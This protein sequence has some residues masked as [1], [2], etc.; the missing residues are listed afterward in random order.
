VFTLGPMAHATLVMII[1]ST[2]G[3]IKFSLAI[4]LSENKFDNIKK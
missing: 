4:N 1:E 3:P 2:L